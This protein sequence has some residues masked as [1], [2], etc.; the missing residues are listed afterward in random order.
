LIAPET[1]KDGLFTLNEVE[2]LGAC[3]NA[4]M[5]QI[6]NQHFYVCKWIKKNIIHIRPY[7]RV[8]PDRLTDLSVVVC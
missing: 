7:A 2:C 6:N 1:T 8:A 3:V 4:P 5:M